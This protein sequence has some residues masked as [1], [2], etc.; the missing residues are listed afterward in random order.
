MVR[1]ML[2]FPVPRVEVQ[3]L[4]SAQMEGDGVLVG[5]VPGIAAE[6]QHGGHAE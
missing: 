5:D 3:A 2:D 1:D 4:I 6:S